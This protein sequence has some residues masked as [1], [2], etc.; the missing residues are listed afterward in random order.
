MKTKPFKG[1]NNK[2]GDLNSQDLIFET[3]Q[4]F[5]T[6]EPLLFETVKN[7]LTD[8]TEANIQV[9]ILV[10][11]QDLRGLQMSRF[12]RD[13]LFETFKDFMTVE[14]KVKIKVSILVSIE[15]PRLISPHLVFNAE[16]VGH[17]SSMC[18]KL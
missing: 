18:S 6:V 15:I 5:S 3:V 4:D 1:I 8:K 7:F 13:P 10:M 17:L 14:T 11:T 16:K 9:S 2:P 12:C